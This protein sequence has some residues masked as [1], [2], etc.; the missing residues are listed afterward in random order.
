MPK[1]RKPQPKA[2]SSGLRKWIDDVHAQLPSD[3]KLV[4]RPAGESKI[5]TVFAEFIDPF[6][7]YATNQA[8]YIKLIGL[9]VSAWNAAINAL[10]DSLVQRKT[11]Y[12]ADDRR[13]ILQYHLEDTG[14]GYQL[15]M[16][17]T[18]MDE[19]KNA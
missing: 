2:R 6:T 13:Y 12:F 5:S 7:E 15:M 19:P 9:G 3:A 8:G 18:V 11:Q 4:Q 10:L 1:R 16:V 17:S 14:T